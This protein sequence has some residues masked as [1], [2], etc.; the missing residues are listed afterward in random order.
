MPM[1]SVSVQVYC[2][3]FCLFASWLAFSVISL[4]SIWG[5]WARLTVPVRNKVEKRTAIVA[6]ATRRRRRDFSMRDIHS[7]GRR[8]WAALRFFGAVQGYLIRSLLATGR[9]SKVAVLACSIRGSGRTISADPPRSI[10]RPPR[11][12]CNFRQSECRR[13]R[14]M[15]FLW[16]GAESTEGKSSR[17]YANWSASCRDSEYHL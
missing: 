3:S 14:Y 2:A 4:S 15:R 13:R 8:H 9:S 5:F 10:A 16:I 17:R 11:H 7:S 6:D 12:C 1:L